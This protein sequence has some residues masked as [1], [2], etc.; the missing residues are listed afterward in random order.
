M[1][2]LIA[3]AFRA[4]DGLFF[5]LS[6]VFLDAEYHLELLTTLFA[7]VFVC[8]HNLMSSHWDKPL[9]LKTW[10]CLAALARV[11]REG[12]GF[13]LDLQ[14]RSPPRLCPPA[15]DS[16]QIPPLPTKVKPCSSFATGTINQLYS[17]CQIE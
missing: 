3:L 12:R 15:G 14:S 7:F 13:V 1:L 8:W 9:L 16:S 2:D 10:P 6:F 11:G 5:V 4:M 17:S